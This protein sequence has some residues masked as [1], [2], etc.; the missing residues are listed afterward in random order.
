M[1][2]AAFPLLSAKLDCLRALLRA[3]RPLIVAFSGGVDSS[4]L[5]AVAYQELG[6]D[7]L[8]VTAV[9]ASLPQDELADAERVAGQLGMPWQTVVTR[10]GDRLEYV[11]NGPDRCYH[12]RTELFAVL[13]PLARERGASVA[14]GTVVD[15]LDDYRPGGKAAEE[16]EVLTPLLQAGLRKTEVR[17]LARVLGL[18][19]W[20]K[21]AA[22]CLASRIP[23]GTPVTLGV[24]SQVER[25]E[26]ALRKRGFRALRVRHYGKLA[27]IEV[28]LVDFSRLLD[29]R[30]DVVASVR[31]AGYRYVTLDL[32]GLRSGNLNPVGDSTAGS[33]PPLPAEAEAGAGSG[34]EA[35]AGSASTGT[36][37]GFTTNIAVEGQ[38]CGEQLKRGRAD[39]GITGEG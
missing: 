37:E 16:W 36:E 22:A 9:S 21:P 11:A 26:A 17:E 10:E 24:L 18:D 7:M 8:S 1:M 28:P 13:S 12:C 34:S 39:E 2:D 23:S 30:A 15:D 27:R 35:G 3:A 5:A 29:C 38:Y 6:D 25:A 20:D 14:V 31:G 32:E 4:L 33:L 19:V